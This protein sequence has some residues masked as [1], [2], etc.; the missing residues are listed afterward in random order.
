MPEK[1]SNRQS[2]TGR[3]PDK[4]PGLRGKRAIVR[5]GI[6]IIILVKTSPHAAVCA[7]SFSSSTRL[8]LPARHWDLPMEAASE[9]YWWDGFLAGPSLEGRERRSCYCRG[10][11]TAS[12]NAA[13]SMVCTVFPVHGKGSTET[14]S[15]WRLFYQAGLALAPNFMSVTYSNTNSGAGFGRTFCISSC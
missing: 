10:N 1:R 3:V 14:T 15:I 9:A 8:A 2:D 13:L 12:T 5:L 6:I 7:S 11:Q 4:R